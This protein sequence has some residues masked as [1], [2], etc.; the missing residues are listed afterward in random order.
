MWYLPGG[1]QEKGGDLGLYALVAK[2]GAVCQRAFKIV[3]GALVAVWAPGRALLPLRV[4]LPSPTAAGRWQ[5]R[6]SHPAGGAGDPRRSASKGAW[7]RC[8]SP[9]RAGR[10]R[11][12]HQLSSVFCSLR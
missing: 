9:A 1:S 5:R 10:R 4:C 2:R 7:S 12:P 6:R 8:A 11:P 3:P